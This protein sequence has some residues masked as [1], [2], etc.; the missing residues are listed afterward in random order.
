MELTQLAEY[1]PVIGGDGCGAAGLEVGACRAAVAAG[2]DAAGVEQRFHRA[3][4]RIERFFGA[5]EQQPDHRPL[6]RER[7]VVVEVHI[8]HLEEAALLGPAV[9]VALRGI[10]HADIQRG[11]HEALI[12]AERVQQPHGLPLFI[13]RGQ[14]KRIERGRAGEVVVVHLIGAER[15]ER[16]LHPV[17]K[18]ERTVHAAGERIA[19]HERRRDVVIAVDARDFLGDVRIRLNSGFDIRAEVRNAHLEPVDQR[20]AVDADRFEHFR[21]LRGG[22]V[23]REQAVDVLDV[24]IGHPFAQVGCADIDRPADDPAGVQL[25]DK[26]DRAVER[27]LRIDRLHALDEARGRIR[28]MVELARRL[29]DVAA[30]EHGGFKQNRLRALRDL[31]VLA[32]H[33]ARDA[34]ALLRVGDEQHIRRD[35]ALLAVERGDDLVFLRVADDDMAAGNAGEVERVHG[36]AIFHEHIVRDIH[37]VVDRPHA[38]AAQ[39]LLHPCGRRLDADVGDDARG[40][41]RAERGVFNGHGGVVGL[42]A[43]TGDLA[44][45]RLAER[46]PE[47][48]GGFAADADD[49]CAVRTVRRELD[50]EH[51]A[52]QPDGLGDRLAERMLLLQQQDA[53]HLAAGVIGVG[54]A[55]LLAGAEHAVAV[56]TAHIDRLHDLVAELCADQRNRHERT[57]GY[58]LRTGDD[59]E[60]LGSDVH[61]TDIE[62]I[63]VFMLDDGV[64]AADDHALHARQLGIDRGHLEPAPHHLLHEL[65]VRYVVVHIFLEPAK[66]QFHNRF[67][68]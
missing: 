26:L 36:M 23:E 41:A 16:V 53:V 51:H 55:Q 17:L 1:A 35:R 6:L 64:D 37:D 62:V 18:G 33:H 63:G 11:A 12:L 57:G 60:H 32:A 38:D 44:D 22:E 8:A 52:V 28:H 49:R 65:L 68:P 21:H 27:E 7:F 31:G 15:A 46:L 58:V 29:A 9:H 50:V 5:E 39:L 56:H 4:E 43:G 30:L 59:L 47:R 45:F 54:Q 25:I 61:L 34:N 48:G 10:E 40:I 3:L 66:R 67:P 2:A 42:I 13:L 24:H 19:P 14:A 20:N